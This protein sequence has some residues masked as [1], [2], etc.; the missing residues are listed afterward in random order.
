MSELEIE[1][2][3]DEIVRKYASKEYTKDTDLIE[4]GILESLTLV[5]IVIEIENRMGIK[6]GIDFINVENFS[7]LNSIIALVKRLSDSRG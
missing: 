7:T 6:I 5:E 1:K 2:N 3:V 4:N